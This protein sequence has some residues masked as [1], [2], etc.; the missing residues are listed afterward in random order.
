M[1]LLQVKNLSI[2][3][4]PQGSETIDVVKSISFAVERGKTMALV[5]ES[6]SGK[7]VSALSILGLLPYPVATHP[8]GSILFDGEELLNRGEDFLRGYRGNK[9]GMIFQE[10][11]TALNPLHT[12]EQQIAETLIIHKHMTPLQA[13]ARVL[14]L[15]DLVGFKDGRNRLDA[16]PHQLSGGQRQRVM[17]AMALACEPELLIADEPTTAL[18]VTIQAGIIELIKSLQQQFNMGLVLIS[19]DLNMV[20]RIA[21]DIAV[22]KNGEIVEQGE[23]DSI[24]LNP[25]HPYT[26]ALIAAEPAGNPLTTPMSDKIIDVDHLSVSF[27]QKPA[28]F[29]QKPELFKA[30]DGVSLALHKGETL[31][32]VGESGSGKSTLAYAIL[33]LVPSQGKIIYAGQSIDGLTMKQMRLLRKQ[34]Q[35]IFQDPFSS[36]NPRFSVQ[37][38]IAEGLEVHTKMTVDEIEAA[39]I[40]ILTEVGLPEES[41]HRYPHEFSGGQR[42]RICIARALVLRPDV[43]VLD[44][45]TSALDRSIQAEVI[46]LLRTLQQKYTLSYLFISHDLKVVKA[47]SHR[48]IVMKDGQIVEQG[49]TDDIVF[50]A[51]S[52]YAKK[53]MGAA[54]N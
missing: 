14:E 48:I 36:L 27:K 17:I 50:H 16:Y 33:K 43:L 7:S 23:C 28:W 40:Q 6:G 4:S 37:Q 44:E 42:Q 31:G 54:F 32:I 18:D 45:P 3:F 38:I 9:I 15:L 11:M 29:W 53:L 51:K 24:L 5:G 49:K 12:L 25:Q 19:H 10:P 34:L 13:R 41:R 35:I 21:D 46:D 8:S 39:V 2:R 22:M 20:K 52:D 30:I 26:Q 47:M 1:S